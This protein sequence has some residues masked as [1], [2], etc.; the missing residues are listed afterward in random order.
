MYEKYHDMRIDA[1]ACQS[2]AI[3]ARV[4]RYAEVHVTGGMIFTVDFKITDSKFKN[5]N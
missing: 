5:L 1:K 2:P 4:G 3:G